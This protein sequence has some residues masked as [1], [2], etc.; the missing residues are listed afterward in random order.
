MVKFIRPVLESMEDRLVL[1]HNIDGLFGPGYYDLLGVG[2]SVAQGGNNLIINLPRGSKAAAHRNPNYRG[3]QSNLFVSKIGQQGN[4]DLFEIIANGHALRLQADIDHIRVQGSPGGNTISFTSNVSEGTEVHGSNYRDL[5]QGGSGSDHL[6]GKNGN[7]ILIGGGGDDALLGGGGNDLLVGGHGRDYL[8]GDSGS[9]RYVGQFN[10]VEGTKRNRRASWIPTDNPILDANGD[11]LEN[12]RN[13]PGQE[14]DSIIN[15]IDFSPT[16]TPLLADR[17]GSGNQPSPRDLVFAELDFYDNIHAYD[18]FATRQGYE[19]RADGTFVPLLLQENMDLGG[20]LKQFR[21]EIMGMLDSNSQ[22]T[23]D[24]NQ[25]QRLILEVMGSYD[26]QVNGTIDINDLGM[27][28]LAAEKI[29]PR[30]EPE[31]IQVA[32]RGDGQ[33][34][35]VPDSTMRVNYHGP[36]APT[37]LTNTQTMNTIN[38]FVVL[39]YRQVP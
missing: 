11:V 24:L 16:Q 25:A 39:Q 13:I 14:R 19:K 15:Q 34:N 29:V 2:I 31:L 32:R 3:A 10:S 23:N 35:Y 30:L 33:G 38:Q 26:Q 5:I 18:L 27:N 17:G 12:I 1:S 20:D 22:P 37:N 7:D 21:F 8:N 36:L 4:L 28:T 6:Y 9:D